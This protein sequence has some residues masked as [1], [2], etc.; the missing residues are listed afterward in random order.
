MHQVK[1]IAITLAAF[2]LLL[3]LG[4]R[5]SSA[6]EESYKGVITDSQCAMNVHSLSKSHKEML[7]DKTIGSTPAD[8]VWYCVKQRGGRFVLQNKD[9]VYKLDDQTMGRDFAGK[10]VE[11]FGTLN[12]QTNTIHVRR[13]QPLADDDKSVPTIR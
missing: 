3:L 10:K 9:K 13:L 1:R 7:Q 4:L 11:V 5:Q 8:C 6:A 12:T 2:G